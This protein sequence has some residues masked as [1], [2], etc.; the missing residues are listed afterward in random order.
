M[1]PIAGYFMYD[2][3]RSENN[4]NNNNN[5]NNYTSSNVVMTTDSPKDQSFFQ[6]Q[7]SYQNESTSSTSS[8]YNKPSLTT[9]TSTSSYPQQAQ[10]FPN[11]QQPPQ[12]QIY[13]QHLKDPSSPS[14]IISS[15]NNNNNNNNNNKRPPFKNGI[16]NPT[17]SSTTTTTTT[18]STS[19]QK[20]NNNNNNS[21]YSLSNSRSFT[22]PTQQSQQ[23]ST[24]SNLYDAC[25]VC[26][27][28]RRLCE[29]ETIF[30]KICHRNYPCLKKYIKPPFE[31]SWR[32]YYNLRKSSFLVLGGPLTQ[33]S[34]MD[35]ICNKLRMAGIGRVEYFYTQ[36]R[37]PTLKELQ[38]YTSVLIYSYNSSAFADG[39]QM[40][41]V[42]A[43]YVDNGGGVVVT[44]FTNC[45]NLRNGFL[46]GKF[47]EQNY[48]PII[49]SRQHDTNGKKALNL[50]KVH[51][52]NHP[53]MQGVKN[54]EGGRSSF[55]CNGGLN[56][57]AKLVAEWSNG[58]PLIADLAKNKGKV[59]ALN[60]F[61]PS[62][63]TGDPRFW[64]S[65][66]DGSTLMAN[67]L[68]YAGRSAVM[69]KHKLQLSESS[70]S[71]D[72]KIKDGE[73]ASGST[74]EKDS[75]FLG[76]GKMGNGNPFNNNNNNNGNNQ[77]SGFW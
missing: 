7:L 14:F 26:Q 57:E 32:K 35:D 37:I 55:Y 77:S 52:P 70:I 75:N 38:K 10:Q 40:G 22:K 63:D 56:V 44:V 11:Q 4:N 36:K 68:V 65:N 2:S 64:S 28:W 9:T 45:N 19:D 23:K 59:V 58:V 62:S 24:S 48:H 21:V 33:S 1:N 67:S 69:K 3:Q 17:S 8:I 18:T 43:D 16:T 71:L 53:I 39:Q 73:G 27:F 34:C 20:N 66:T 47:L 54:L 60:F 41:D 50:G 46:K 6:Q 25:F 42:L 61:P 31:N 49:P 13:Y 12:S 74:S 29:D 5:N 51:I 76:N 15:N 30:R 72:G